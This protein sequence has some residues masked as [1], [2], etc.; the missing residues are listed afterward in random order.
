MV[1]YTVDA[2]PAGYSSGAAM[3]KVGEVAPPAP[4]L[5]GDQLVPPQALNTRVKHMIHK[6]SIFFLVEEIDIE[7]TLQKVL[8]LTIAYIIP[9][10]I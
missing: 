3:V 1:R 7:V 2:T 10:Q 8:Q 6:L 4:P 5:L 9:P